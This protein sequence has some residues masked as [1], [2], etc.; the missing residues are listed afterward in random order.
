MAQ[1]ESATQSDTQHLAKLNTPFLDFIWLLF[2]VSRRK[3]A[4]TL[5]YILICFLK[6]VLF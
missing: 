5:A 3:I 6:I 4:Q 2:L 1:H